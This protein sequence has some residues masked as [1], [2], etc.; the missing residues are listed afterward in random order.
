[1]WWRGGGVRSG[2]I[3]A[4]TLSGRR[5]NDLPYARLPLRVPC[6]CLSS[7]ALC[8][9]PTPVDELIARQWLLPLVEMAC[10]SS[11]DIYRLLAVASRTMRR[12]V[13]NL[14]ESHFHA[15]R[16]IFFHGPKNHP[17][18]TRTPRASGCLALQ[19]KWRTKNILERPSLGRWWRSLK[20][21]DAY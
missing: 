16:V 10:A 14:D 21:G 13:T 19:Q 6:T 1:M 8:P 12:A 2:A 4:L 5:F 3:P 15:S 17:Q 20:D 11:S 9:P 7:R 18:S